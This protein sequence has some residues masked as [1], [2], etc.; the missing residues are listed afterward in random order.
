MW[1]YLC[2]GVIQCFYT[3]MSQKFLATFWLLFSTCSYVLAALF[4]ATRQRDT[5]AL[6]P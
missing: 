4:S 5:C 3:L 2:S 6:N 1:T